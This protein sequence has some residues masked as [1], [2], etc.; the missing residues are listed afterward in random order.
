MK[1][2]ITMCK[3]EG[4]RGPSLFLYFVLYLINFSLKRSPN[5][6]FGFR[7]VRLTKVKKLKPVEEKRLHYFDNLDVKRNDE[8]IYRNRAKREADYE[9]NAATNS[10]KKWKR[11]RIIPM[12]LLREGAWTCKDRDQKGNAVR[13]TE[14]GCNRHVV[15]EEYERKSQG[16]SCQDRDIRKRREIQTKSIMSQLS[17]SSNNDMESFVNDTTPSPFAHFTTRQSNVLPCEPFSAE[18]VED[19]ISLSVADLRNCVELN[20]INGNLWSEVLEQKDK[21]FKFGRFL[22]HFKR[23]KNAKGKGGPHI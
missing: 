11:N 10:R 3:I 13:K 5:S 7:V 18:V 21:K 1:R 15:T 8:G 4:N 17:C 6:R 19:D 16:G 23:V 22:S 20:F 12:M 2:E 9:L 14:Y